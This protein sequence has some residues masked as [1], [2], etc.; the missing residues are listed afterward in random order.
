M[1]SV[2]TVEFA[3]VFEDELPYVMATLRRLGARTEDLQDLAQEVFVTVHRIFDDYDPSRAIRPWLFGIAYRV[4]LRHRDLARHKREIYEAAPD[5]SD[6]APLP[7][8]QLERAEARV[9]VR[10]AMDRIEVHRRAVFVLSD[11]EGLS[12]PEIASTLGIPLNTAYSRL[13]RA[14]EDFTSAV[15]TLQRGERRP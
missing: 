2:G 10:A 1:G 13:R 9:L 4:A 14:R 15:A 11:L 8:T 6:T 5:A 12:V 3:Q 7:D